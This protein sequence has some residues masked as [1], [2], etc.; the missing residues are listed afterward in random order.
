MDI[1]AKDNHV[2]PVR[3]EVVDELTKEFMEAGLLDGLGDRER[4]ARLALLR[5]LVNEGFSIEDLKRAAAEDRLGLLPVDRVLAGEQKYTAREV[6]ELAETPL[7]FLLAVRQA[8]GFAIPGPDERPFSD[9]DVEA[10]RT[11]ARLRDAGLPEDALLEVIRVLG[12]G[13]AQGAEAMRMA[14][15]RWLLPQGVDEYELSIRTVQAARELLP[16]TGPLLDYTLKE[17]MR[18][19]LRH[20]QYGGL[21]L[22]EGMRPSMRQVYVGFSDMVGFTRLGELI[23]IEE[24][25]QVLGKLTN[26]ARE[27]VRQPTR[28]VKTIGDAIMFVGPAPA[29]LV[30]TVLTLT[31]RVEAEDLPPIRSGL[32]AGLA[33]SRDGDWY[34]PPVNLASRVTGVARPGTVLATKEMRDDA[35]DSYSWSPAGEWRLKGVKRPVRLYRAGRPRA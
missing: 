29:A 1:A 25:G 30:E 21:E 15:A 17:H 7:E 23:E 9:E 2:S 8:M 32:A 18:D 3:M 34:G 13:L 14:V 27:A 5:E 11:L 24:L 33:L 12:N 4:A 26:L 20:Q 35:R 19:Q 10:T 22:T 16:L 31:E 6:A 28:L